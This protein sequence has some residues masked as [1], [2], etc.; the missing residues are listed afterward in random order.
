MMQELTYREALH[1]AL[2]EEMQ[3]DDRVIVLGEDIADPFGGPFKV[4]TGLSTEFGTE[5]V[6]NTPISESAMIGCTVGSA[7]TGM[8]PVAELSYID[9]T[10]C[11]M[12]QICNQAAKIRFMTGGQVTVPMV[13]RTEGGTGRSSAAQHAQSLEAWFTHVPGLLVVMPST[14]AD[15]K[16]LLKSAIRCDDPVMFIEH[17]L[18]YNSKGLVPDG[19]VTIPIGKAEV[20][21]QGNDV[22]IVATSRMVL[23]A[24]AAAETLAKEGIEAEVIDPRTLVPLDKRAIL[25]SVEKTGR[26]VIV[27]EAVKRSGFGAELAAMVAEEALDCLDAP[28]IRVAGANSP[29][30]FAPKLEVHVIP[31]A[32]KIAAAVRQSMS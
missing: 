1:Q 20:K 18:L 30:P 6:R 2:R 23:E 32:D 9:F 17:K 31:N 13:I 8:R 15:A 24:L 7:I 26:L 14:P 11:A 27:H 25:G 19:D 3:R 16:G 21:R 22:T 10:T 12:D 28:I 5:R 4:T 29:M